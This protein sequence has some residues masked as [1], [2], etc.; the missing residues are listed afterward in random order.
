MVGTVEERV[1]RIE[2][3][4]Q[5]IEQLLTRGQRETRRDL[6]LLAIQAQLTDLGVTAMLCAGCVGIVG[7]V[8]VGAQM[9][10]SAKEN[11]PAWAYNMIWGW[12]GDSTSFSNGDA[13]KVVSAAVAWVGK[14]FKPGESARCA[15]WVRE[16]LKAAGV[17]IGVAKGSAGPL[18]ADSFHGAELGE[19]ILDASQLQPGDIVMFADTYDGP[20]RSPIPGRGRITHVGIYTGNGKMVDRSTRS[21]PVRERKISIFKFHSALRP[22]AYKTASAGGDFVDRY[23][24][25]VAKQESGGNY[26]S[27]NPHSGALGKYQFMPATLASTAQS[28]PGVNRVPSASEFLG[29]PDLQNAIMG[30]YVGRALPTIQAKTSDEYTQCRMMASY[31]YSGNPDKYDNGSAQSYNGAAYPSIAAYTKSVCKGF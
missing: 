11:M 22:N 5:R 23:M 30:C 20:G 4:Q 28:C 18:M 17:N 2:Q 15:D 12:A 29:N 21:A 14:D 27:V 16:V 26:T 8:F 6:G 13:A 25:R 9:R 1:E 31:H 24:K 7:A 3:G 10:E 19:I